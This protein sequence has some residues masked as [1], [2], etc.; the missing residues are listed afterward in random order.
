[1]CTPYTAPASSLLPL[2]SIV[3]KLPNFG[4]Q[5]QLAS[6]IVEEHIQTRE[7]IKKLLNAL[8]GGKVLNGGF[9]FEV[10]KG[11]VF[12]NLEKLK[13]TDLMSEEMLEYYTDQ[14]ARNGMHGTCECSCR[15]Y[16]ELAAEK[17]KY[18]GT[19]AGSRISRTSCSKSLM[20]V[21][22]VT[23][24]TIL[25]YN[26][27][28]NKTISIPVLF[29]Q[30]INDRALPLAMSEGMEQYMPKL[31]RGLVA[32]SHWALWEAPE[33]VNDLI[34]KWLERVDKTRSTL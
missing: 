22:I 19:A 20:P 9:G 27:L 21:Q 16:I 3:K 12:E 24:G 14:Y 26:R 34:K 33:Q 6:G 13:K 29:I 11:V 32:T 10:T 25:T 4:Y 8:Y 31:T 23:S 2:E 28:E 30:A 7:E 15:I 17:R 18:P 1:M 5:I